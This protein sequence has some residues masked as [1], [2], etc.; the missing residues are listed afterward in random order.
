MCVRY[1]HD[2][3]GLLRLTTVEVVVD[4]APVASR[5]SDN[6]VYGVRI[7]WDEAELR[8]SAMAHGAIWDNPAKLWR[9]R[10]KVVKLL[11]LYTRVKEK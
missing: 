10:G 7:A 6:H 5:R 4:E 3:A 9:I 11:K 8:A 2:E 1:R